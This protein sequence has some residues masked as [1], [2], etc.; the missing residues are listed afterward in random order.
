M[1]KINCKTN[2]IHVVCTGLIPVLWTLQMSLHHKSGLLCDNYTQ[3]WLIMKWYCG[4]ILAMIGSIQKV[5][6]GHIPQSDSRDTPSRHEMEIKYFWKT[7]LDDKESFKVTK[8]HY[9]QIY[10]WEITQHNKQSYKENTTQIPHFGNTSYSCH[11]SHQILPT[12][13]EK[14]NNNHIPHNNKN[15]NPISAKLS[16]NQFT[17][18]SHSF[19]SCHLWVI[20][21]FN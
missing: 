14:C 12:P 21:L 17:P 7:F 2:T 20:Y 6:I 15:K 19:F 4:V 9:K 10:I 13:M 18:I 3:A 11:P 16:T 5:H 8:N 1:L